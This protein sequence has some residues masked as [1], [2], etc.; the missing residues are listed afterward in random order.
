M[1]LLFFFWNSVVLLLLAT[2]DLVQAYPESG[3]FESQGPCPASHP[4]RV[5]QVMFEVIYETKEFNDPTLWPEDGSQP[6]VYSFGDG[7]GYANHGDYLFGWK[8]DALQK[9]MDE[10]CFVNCSSMRTQSIQA[11]NACTTT[12]KVDEDIGDTNC[13]SRQYLSCSDRQTDVLQG[14]LRFQDTTWIDR[15]VCSSWMVT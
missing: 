7:T 5:P 8:D 13:E 11:M 6:F 3:T 9:I 1:R 14:S 4:V 2:A 12:R 10:E 15:A